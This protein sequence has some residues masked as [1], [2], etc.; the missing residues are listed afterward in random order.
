M[1]KENA[2]KKAYAAPKMRVVKLKFQEKLLQA[3]CP[4]P[5]CNFQ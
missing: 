4:G 2:K 1:K 3:S 5:Q